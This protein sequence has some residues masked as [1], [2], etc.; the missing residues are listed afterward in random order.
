VSTLRCR[1]LAL[2]MLLIFL[3]GCTSWKPTTVAPAEVIQD[4]QPSQVRVTRTDGTRLT[5]LR[6]SVRNDSIAA[7]E[8]VCSGNFGCYEVTNGVLPLG[9]VALLEVRRLRTS[10]AAIV[11]VPVAV[12]LGYLAWVLVACRGGRCE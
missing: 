11:L 2:F 6:P 4:E 8:R 7:P 12:G 9:D 10:T 5:I 3:S 1:P